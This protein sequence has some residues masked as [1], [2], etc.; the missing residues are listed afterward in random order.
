MTPAPAPVRELR[1]IAE[2]CAREG[3]GILKEARRRGP[4]AVREKAPNDFVTEADAASEAA[5]TALLRERRPQDGLLA[6]EAATAGSDG[7]QPVSSAGA[8]GIGW[9]V[10]PLDGTRNFI[11]GFP[12]YAVSVAARGA[13]GLLAGAIYDP[14][15]DELFSAGRGEGAT[16]DGEPIHVTA[17]EPRS[18]L[19]G[20]GFP[21]RHGHLREAY[22]ESFARVNAAVSDIRRAG[23][24]SL[25]LAYVACGRLDGFWELGLSPWD[26]AAGWL[27]IEEAGGRVTD[28]RGGGEVF[29]RGHIVAGG[30]I[31]HRALLELVRPAFEG[32]VEALAGG[33]R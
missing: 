8:S 4:R 19:V 30:A 28:E 9:I 20:T 1:E 22:L 23:S 24:A 32:R 21:F 16:L 10:D 11:H 17:A 31:L 27:L 26:M 33:A 14:T 15:R 13:Q 3:G 6:E 7:P 18:A 25:D 2:A 5:I 12:A 29:E